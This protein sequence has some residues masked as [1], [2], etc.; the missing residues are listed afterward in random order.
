[1]M[2]LIGKFLYFFAFASIVFSIWTYQTNEILGVFI[3]LWVP[4]LLLLGPTCPWR[5]DRSR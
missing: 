2:D 3:G 5:K 4:T 1:M